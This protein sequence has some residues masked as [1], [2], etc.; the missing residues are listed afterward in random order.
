MRDELD[1]AS[2]FD[3][4]EFN[5]LIERVERGPEG[6]LDDS[7]QELEARYEGVAADA[8]GAALKA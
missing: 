6:W 5:A 4:D 7:N 8:E 3:P 2:A 1:P